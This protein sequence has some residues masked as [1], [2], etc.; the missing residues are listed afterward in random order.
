MMEKTLSARDEGLTALAGGHEPALAHGG[1][2]VLFEVN[3]TRLVTSGRC[4]RSRCAHRDLLRAPLPFDHALL[5]ENVTPVTVA[6][7]GFSS[8]APF[9]IHSRT[10]CSSWSLQEGVIARVRHSPMDFSISVLSSGMARFSDDR[11]LAGD[12]L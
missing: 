6:T 11:H 10:V 3:R 1:G 12:R 8:T 9:W 2:G 5:G 7:S 4:R